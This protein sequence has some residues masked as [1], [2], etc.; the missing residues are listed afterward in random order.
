MLNGESRE[1]IGEFPFFSYLLADLHPHVLAMP[2]ILLAAALALNLFVG[3]A[4]GSFSLSRLRIPLNFPSFLFAAVALGSLGFMNTWDF[5]MAVAL[6]AGAY[7]FSVPTT[8]FE[9]IK[10]FLK[11]SLTL[12]ISG[13]LLYL[14][15][16]LGFSSQA[17]GLLPNLI[18][19]TRGAHLWVQFGQFF[20]PIFALLIFFYARQRNWR[21]LGKG[22]GAAAGITLI[23]WLLM[24]L[25]TLLIAILPSLSSLNAQAATAPDL[26]LGSL[27]ADNWSSLLREAFTRR[28]ENPGGWVTLFLLLGL[29]IGLLIEEDRTGDKGLGIRDWGLGEDDEGVQEDGNDGVFGS[30]RFVLLLVLLGGLLVYALE[31]VFL[32]D[33]FGYRLNSVFK[34]YYQA[35]I[36][37]SIAASYALIV[38]VVEL[39]RRWIW[40]FSA[41]AVAVLAMALVY[42]AYGIVER[43]GFIDDRENLTLD[44]A[45]YLEDHAPDE[46]AAIEWLREAQP[47]VIV[48]AVAPGG[49]AYTDYAR[50]SEYSGLPAVIGWINHEAQWRGGYEEIGSRQQDVERLYTTRNWD[51]ASEIL[52]MYDIRYVVVGSRERATYPRLNQAKFDQFLTIVFQNGGVTVYEVPVV[53]EQ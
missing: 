26:F 3:G 23:L 52:D 45:V 53:G 31:F 50:I 39:R 19:V 4:R 41:A 8:Y 14:P 48:E 7:V 51:E 47:G 42:P 34:F 37:W 49:G 38:L 30:H 35:W 46:L 20:L 36:L 32:R 6:F 12:G 10:D 28:L 16:Y 1:I 22:L 9:K 27:G 29:V 2:Y 43:L 40:T 15:F 25:L 17:G 18:Y 5:P 21:S 11:L 44:G 33:Q 13:I 24:L